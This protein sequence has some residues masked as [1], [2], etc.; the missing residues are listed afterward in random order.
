MGAEG[1]EV[2]GLGVRAPNS[3]CRVEGVLCIFS[4]FAII[5]LPLDSSPSG[6]KIGE[7]AGSELEAFFIT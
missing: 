4:G 1:L 7:H 3:A 6:F 5:S 2:L